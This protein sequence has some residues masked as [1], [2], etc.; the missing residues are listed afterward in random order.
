VEL[1]AISR[2]YNE[3]KEGQTKLQATLEAARE[4]AAPIFVST[5]ST[6]IVFLPIVFLTGIAKL[7]FVP[8]AVTIAVA[9]FGS[10]FVSRTVTPLMC[11]RFLPP[12]KELDRESRK[13]GDRLRMW[14]HDL[15]A[16]VDSWYSNRLQWA[17]HHRRLVIGVIVAV[18]LI[19]IG[20]TK[21]IGTEFFPDQD[22]GQ[23]NISIRLPV[24]VRVEVTDQ[25]ARQVEQILR[26][27]VPE[28]QTIIT[29][30]GVPSARSGS[31]FSPNTGSHA[32]VVRVAL[33]PLDQRRRSVFQIV[34]SL[35]PELAAIPGANIFVNPSGFLRFLLNFGTSAPID[36]EISGFDLDTG[37]NLAAQIADIVRSTPGTSD[38]Y[39][40]RE[41]NLPELDIKIDRR[42]AGVLG[43]D[44]AQ[45]A[46]TVN[47]C[48]AGAVASLY[49]DPVSGNQYNILVRLDEKY[50]SSISDLQNVVLTTSNGQPVLLGN[51][52]TIQRTS[53]PVEIDRKYQQRLIEVTAN[54]SGRPLG[55]VAADIQARIDK[56]AIPPGFQVRQSGNVA[57]QKQTFAALLLA[58]ALSIML[59]YVVMASQ[60]QSMLDPFI[61]MFTVPLGIIGVFWMLFLTGTTLSV[62]SFQGIIVMVGVVV[63][64]GILLVDY[65]NRL[66][67]RGLPLQEAVVTAGVTRLK[68]IVMTSLA[69]VLGLI[70][71][72]LGIGG[73]KTQAPLAIAVIGGLTVSTGLTLF[74]VPILY[75]IFEERFKR[76]LRSEINGEPPSQIASR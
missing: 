76:E 23:F 30:V 4:V 72:A 5:L 56:L 36:I 6:V 1:E 64:N 49:F 24:G 70:P 53:S 60:F 25:M 59:V 32:A 26:R 15:I 67:R 45:V 16:S 69:T 50:R 48:I 65:T 55:S 40:T 41:G 10:F 19:S 2:H 31:L 3:R 9:L 43:V 54:A 18:A 8:L 35:R 27:D 74:F 39:A 68:P 7:L 47:A 38:V 71:M 61:I 46:N 62:T 13:I 14:S 66:R 11:L 37:S 63:S 58:F 75:T 22:E 17:L 29:D 21:F 52:A 34:R 51:I 28:I 20:L 42:K 12:E 33:V 57:Q 44:V 73:E